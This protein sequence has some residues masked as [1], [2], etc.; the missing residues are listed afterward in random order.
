M[1]EF[2]VQEIAETVCRLLQEV[3]YKLPPDVVAAV[4]ASLEEETFP[5]AR[6]ILE[7]ILLNAEAAEEDRIPLCQDTG[8]VVVF[9]DVGQEVL[10]TGKDLE[11]AIWDA[12][13]AGTKKGFLRCSILRDPLRRENTGDNAP[14]VLHLRIVPGDR[15][16]IAVVPKG[17]GSENMSAMAMLNPSEGEE[18]VIRFV[19]ETVRRAGGK[20]CPPLVVGVGVGGTVEMA[21]L[22]AK[23]SLLRPLGVM[24]EEPDSA[25][26][27]TSMLEK[28]NELNIG[29]L[30]LG[31]RTT[32]LAVH[33][34]RYP[35]HIASL[36]VAVNLQCHAARHR[37][38]VL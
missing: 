3:S 26:L 28:I 37:E 15:V 8:L 19:L 34:E 32:A 12:V 23:R 30:G 11:P 4:T 27:E 20:P 17:G 7:R 22:L 24:T 33:L 6:S 13:R 25:R 5:R 2:P 21:A 38:V 18:G 31:G 14:G 29:P 36:P 16:R 35:C 9:L 10:F 1:R